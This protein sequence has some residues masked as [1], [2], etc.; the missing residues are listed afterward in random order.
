MGFSRD[1]FY[2]FKELYEQGE[3]TPLGRFCVSPI[4]ATS[5]GRSISI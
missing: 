3:A 5:T 1:S 2:H 4:Y